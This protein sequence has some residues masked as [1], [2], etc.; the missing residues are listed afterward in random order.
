VHIRSNE[1]LLRS[2][3]FATAPHTSHAGTAPGVAPRRPRLVPPTNLPATTNAP[4]TTNEPATTNAP[5]D[6]RSA[7]SHRAGLPVAVP[8]RMDRAAPAPTHTRSGPPAPVTT[9]SRPGPPAP[10]GPPPGQSA[11]PTWFAGQGQVSSPLMPSTSRGAPPPS[12]S[13]HRVQPTSLHPSVVSD[14]H[15]A[16]PSVPVPR[17]TDRA[18]PAP[19]YTR[20][21]PP[22][23]VMRQSRSG[24]PAPVGPPPGQSAP[25][26]WSAGQERPPGPLIPSTSRGASPPTAAQRRVQPTS[27][28]PLGVSAAQ[29]L[30]RPQVPHVVANPE[31]AQLRDGRTKQR[32][33]FSP[34]TPSAVPL[35]PVRKRTQ[36]PPAD[37]AAAHGLEGSEHWDPGSLTVEALPPA[38]TGSRVEVP[39]SLTAADV[40]QQPA[41]PAQSIRRPAHGYT[42]ATPTSVAAVPIW[43]APLAKTNAATQMHNSSAAAPRLSREVPRAGSTAQQAAEGNTQLAQAL[44]FS[45]AL[46]TEAFLAMDTLLRVSARVGHYLSPG[47]LAYARS[48][49]AHVQARRPLPRPEYSLFTQTSRILSDRF[50]N[51]L[52]KAEHSIQVQNGSPSP[53]D[54][55]AQPPAEGSRVTHEGNVHAPSTDP[56]KT[57]EA[58]TGAP[59]PF[60]RQEL[61]APQAA[62]GSPKR[63]KRKAGNVVIPTPP[64]P[65]RLKLD[66]V[67]QYV[68]PGSPTAEA[69]PPALTDTRAGYSIPLAAADAQQRPALPA[70][71]IRRPVHGRTAVTPM[72]VPAAPVWPVPLAKRDAATQ[73]PDLLHS[74]AAAAA[75][76]LREA[77]RAGSLARQAAD[78]NATLPQAV[79]SSCI[80]TANRQFRASALASHLAV[81]GRF[82]SAGE[83]LLASS[84]IAIALNSALFGEQFKPSSPH[85]ET[86]R[87]TFLNAHQALSR[88]TP[89]KWSP[90]PPHIL[91]ARAL[92]GLKS[93]RDWTLQRR[94]APTLEGAH[95]ASATHPGPSRQ[96]AP[97]K[98]KAEEALGPDRSTRSKARATGSDNE[99]TDGRNAKV[100]EAS[101]SRP[102]RLDL[103]PC[104]SGVPRC[105]LRAW[106]P[107]VSRYLQAIG[108]YIRGRRPISCSWMNAVPYSLRGLFPVVRWRNIKRM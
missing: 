97:R 74:V 96:N 99:E 68:G 2:A 18:A 48:A 73:T 57:L 13:Q 36:A 82:P 100:R 108:L 24:P 44:S 29:S 107:R 9:Q 76:T 14:L 103:C 86:I 32:S 67:V 7:L 15:R 88:T 83:L 21:G 53:P 58:L 11:P 77:G 10:E 81:L 63:N 35:G 72:S 79:L 95:L 17:S 28:H 50:H 37:V 80:V 102:L 85:S 64:R 20:S 59:A 25:P 30:E 42:A 54:L 94:T 49:I 45:V 55:L 4:A 26:S 22:A 33:L 52:K 38:P 34:A 60:G 41:L 66:S 106:V 40:Q 43:P 51:S 104:R 62:S 6:A 71:S 91:S 75:V 39:I 92:E 61:P 23:P 5:G 16:G 27:L 3:P 65:E 12:A 19:T 31:L 70:Q 56:T 101:T 78:V 98:R 90:C 89:F 87:E 47:E 1:A 84:T 105:R 93:V 69:L 8:R 46:E